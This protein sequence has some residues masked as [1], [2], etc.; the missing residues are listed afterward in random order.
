MQLEVSLVPLRVISRHSLRVTCQ[1][2]SSSGGDSDRIDN[3]GAQNTTE[4]ADEGHD[5]LVRFAKRFGAESQWV[6]P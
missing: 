1:V 6:L 3:H 5:D 4:R 2:R